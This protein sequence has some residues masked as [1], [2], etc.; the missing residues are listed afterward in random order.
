[1]HALIRCMGHPFQ[2]RKD[3]ENPD[4]ATVRKAYLSP[5]RRKLTTTVEDMANMLKKT[6]KGTIDRMQRDF[7]AGDL[8]RFPELGRNVLNEFLRSNLYKYDVIIIKDTDTGTQTYIVADKGPVHPVR[9]GSRDGQKNNARGGERYS[10]RAAKRFS[11]DYFEQKAEAQITDINADVGLDRK[12]IRDSGIKST[13]QVG[14]K[15]QYGS[16]SV[17]VDDLGGNVIIRKDGVGH[18]LR[19]EKRGAPSEN[20][21]VVANAGPI[22]KNSILI[23]ELTPKKDNATGS[24]VLIGIARDQHGTG[25]IVESIVNRFSNELESMDVL[26]SMNAKKELAA[27]NAPGVTL[28]TLPVTSSD[29]SVPSVLR[30]VNDHFSDILPEEVLKHYGHTER[31]AGK[32]GESALYSSRNV[33]KSTENQTETENF[34]KWFGDWEKNPAKASKVVNADGTPKVVY[35]GTNAELKGGAEYLKQVVQ[36]QKKHHLPESA[37]FL[38]VTAPIR[39]RTGPAYRGPH[40]RR[41]RARAGR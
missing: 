18:S 1:M 3:M 27:L 19:R 25:Y 34:K 9:D 10:D 12:A 13:L 37:A 40:G 30:L 11:Y 20:Y 41:R 4:G 15:N 26:Y 31:S 17:Y 35:H 8:S 32:I 39:G 14:E 22:I 36:I 6:Y 29:T 21:I 2:L 7:E 33:Q 16:V 24:Y 28:K 38:P 23:N 5:E